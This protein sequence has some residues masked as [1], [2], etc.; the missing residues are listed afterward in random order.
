M[1]QDYI[2]PTTPLYQPNQ[3]EMT[4]SDSATSNQVVDLKKWIIG[5]VISNILISLGIVAFLIFI[6]YTLLIEIENGQ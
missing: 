4:P 6:Y 2:K 5:S 3:M 1:N